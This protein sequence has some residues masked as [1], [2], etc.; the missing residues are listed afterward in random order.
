[1]SYPDRGGLIDGDRR[2]AAELW[3]GL[4]ERG[5]GGSAAL[6]GRTGFGA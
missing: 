1:M 4:D 3:E 6:D 5:D 2:L